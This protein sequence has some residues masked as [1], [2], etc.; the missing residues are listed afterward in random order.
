[1]AVRNRVGPPV[2]GADF[3]GREAFVDLVWDK[4]QAGHILLAAP[5]RFGKTSVLYSLIDD[6]RPGFKIIHADLEA[7]NQPSE[8]ITELVV[9]LARQDRLSKIV[10]GLTYFPTELWSRFRETVEEVELYKFKV[11][12]KR[13]L[14]RTW[15]QG[16]EELFD[17]IAKWNETLVFIL[18]ELPM[19]IDFMSR[20]PQGRA[21][22]VA[23][24]RWFRALRMS[25]ARGNVRFVV[26]GSIGLGQILSDLGEVASV[27]DLEQLRLQPFP[28]K[29]AAALIDNL[30]KAEKVQLSPACRRK[31]LTLVGTHVPYFLQVLFSE[32]AK[33][34]KQDGDAVTPKLIERIYHE[35]VL[36]VDCKTYFDHYYGR[37]RAYYQ[38]GEERAIKTL[39][40]ELATKVSLQRDICFQVYKHALGTP[41]TEDGFSHLMTNLENDFYVRFDPAASCYEFSCKILRDWWLRHYGLETA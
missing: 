1:M 34:H 35:K 39:L 23:L 14:E 25:P 32:V 29:T 9:Q 20:T 18:D 26:A 41:A 2:R 28:E 22:A 17:R 24:L 30:S 5:R 31:I 38:P 7:F 3:F 12:L 27:N 19:M 13:Q 11:K 15:R 4:L 8:L 36:G 10:S 16:G 21:E 33:C 37:L 40:R 6:P